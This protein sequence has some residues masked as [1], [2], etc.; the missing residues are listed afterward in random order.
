MEPDPATAH[1][2]ATEIDG[3]VLLYVGQLLPHKRPDLLVQAY[4]V[5]VTWLVPTAATR[6]ANNEMTRFMNHAP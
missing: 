4:H 6:A 1:H 3:P 5:L 2:L